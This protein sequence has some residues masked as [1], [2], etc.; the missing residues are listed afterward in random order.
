MLKPGPKPKPNA[1]KKLSG[2]FRKDRARDTTVIDQPG[3]PAMPSF[4]SPRG[5][6]LWQARVARLTAIDVPLR[7]C[8]RLLGHLCELDA[9]IEKIWLSGQ[10]PT[11]AMMTALRTL[12]S[13][14]H[15]AP[16]ARLGPAPG[17]VDSPWDALFQPTAS[18]DA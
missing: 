10:V 8:E 14:F 1:V 12:A 15:E 2:T 18:S 5:K 7:G 3:R 17:K 16:A 9:A 13:L 11:A 6:E 4:L